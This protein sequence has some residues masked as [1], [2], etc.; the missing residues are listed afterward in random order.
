MLKEERRSLQ[1]KAKEK[2]HLL[3]FVLFALRLE[4]KEV[5]SSWEEVN[6][7]LFLLAARCDEEGACGV[8][9]F[10]GS[11]PLRSQLCMSL[12][13]QSLHCRVLF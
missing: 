1:V 4:V 13:S 7:F 11:S 2:N 10:H 9:L 5:A 12:C 6:W 3:V 8:V